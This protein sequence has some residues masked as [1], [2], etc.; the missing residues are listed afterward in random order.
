MKM[1]KIITIVLITLI[2]IT[3][4]FAAELNLSLGFDYGA[5][6]FTRSYSFRDEAI[7]YR[8][9][10]LGVESE[11]IFDNHFGIYATLD[12]NDLNKVKF[13]ESD[14]WGKWYDI[15]GDIFGIKG[16]LGLAYEL[17][18][19]LPVNFE[20]GAGGLFELMGSDYY[21]SISLGLGLRLNAKYFFTKHIALFA[22]F[23]PD[24]I[25]KSETKYDGFSIS[26]KGE[27]EVFSYGLKTGLTINFR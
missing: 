1:K 23:S 20:V 21:S 18:L 27:K 3:S 5:Y 15:K 17:P 8:G 12:L 26:V 13:K 19:K 22:T 24:L 2:G 16:H 11:L 9:P 4:A 6:S 10:G 14:D 25:L 7:M